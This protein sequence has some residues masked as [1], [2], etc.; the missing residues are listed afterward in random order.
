MVNYSLPILEVF[1]D[2]LG[3]ENVLV[4]CMKPHGATMRLRD[5]LDKG[6]SRRLEKKIGAG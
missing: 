3:A 6:L 2:I 1:A 5:W 4:G